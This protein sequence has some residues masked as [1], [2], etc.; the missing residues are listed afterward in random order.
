MSN[1]L[2]LNCVVNVEFEPNIDIGVMI[3]ER[4]H[5]TILCREKGGTHLFGGR[6]PRCVTAS[7]GVRHLPC[8]DDP[9]SFLLVVL[10][11]FLPPSRSE[12]S[13]ETILRGGRR[14]KTG[15]GAVPKFWH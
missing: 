8:G 6:D 5:A 14:H 15:L 12:R 11:S 13:I 7:Q 2:I 4:L 9:A 3:A 1:A 10:S